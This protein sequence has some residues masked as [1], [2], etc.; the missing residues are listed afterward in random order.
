MQTDKYSG[1]FLMIFEK[2]PRVDRRDQ[3]TQ[4]IGDEK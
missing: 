3:K 1:P 4:D 2:Q